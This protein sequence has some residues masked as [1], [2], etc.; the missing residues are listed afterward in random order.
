MAMKQ[1]RLYVL[2][3]VRQNKPDDALGLSFSVSVQD[4]LCTSRTSHIFACVT[5]SAGNICSNVVCAS[6]SVHKI[7][8]TRHDIETCQDQ[9][10]D[11]QQSRFTSSTTTWSCAY[12]RKTEEQEPSNSKRPKQQQDSTD[13]Q[14]DFQFGKVEVGQGG[15][16]GGRQQQKGK[17]KK[18]TKEQLLQEAVQKQKQQQDPQAGAAVQVQPVKLSQ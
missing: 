16:L 15:L 4:S 6:T 13:A 9:E 11:S 17:R 2:C 5:N 18:P 8:K 12:C 7:P 10:V 3:S 1:T 14:A